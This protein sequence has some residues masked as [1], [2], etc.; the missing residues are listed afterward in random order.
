MFRQTL[1]AHVGGWS[2]SIF[3]VGSII[4]FRGIMTRTPKFKQLLSQ[5]K[6]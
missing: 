3:M 4:S 6:V 2:L 1:S 5:S